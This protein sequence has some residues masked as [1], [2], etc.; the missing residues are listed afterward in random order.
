MRVYF[1]TGVFIDFLGPHGN[2]ILRTAD[3][4][5]RTPADVATDAGR[6]FEKVGRAHTGATSCLT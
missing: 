5:G 6:L 2:S 4:R 3:R 1:D